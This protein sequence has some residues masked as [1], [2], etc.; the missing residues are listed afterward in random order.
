M[1]KGDAT[2]GNEKTTGPGS[3]SIEGLGTL[4]GADAKKTSAEGSTWVSEDGRQSYSVVQM[5]S[6]QDL[7]ISV[8]GTGAGSSGRIT[9]RG[10]ANGQLG[11]SLGEETA[12][13]PQGSFLRGDFVKATETHMVEDEPKEY[14]VR[15]GD[16][17]QSTGELQPGAQD[18]LNG[19]A[20][21]DVIYGFDGNDGLA[22]N[23]S[24]MR[25]A[26]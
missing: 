17:Y 20:G 18:V 11:I 7:I 21:G 15:D 12:Q 5:G 8:N 10:W 6:R 16:N 23:Q 4:S 9:V 13:E 2:V 1:A 25:E 24:C 22:V 14:Y 3:I 26:A 19:G